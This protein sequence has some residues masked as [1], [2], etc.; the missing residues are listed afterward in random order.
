M[1]NLFVGHKNIFLQMI[2]IITLPHSVITTAGTGCC[3]AA[4][5]VLLSWNLHGMGHVAPPVVRVGGDS[6]SR[7]EVPSEVPR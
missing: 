5:R 1:Y 3:G 2:S 7:A 4:G 6:E